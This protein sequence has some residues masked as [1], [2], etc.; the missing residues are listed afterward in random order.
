MLLIS[1]PENVAN[2]PEVRQVPVYDWI[3]YA[4]EKS[5]TDSPIEDLLLPDM[6]REDRDLAVR[7]F[8]RSYAL[9]FESH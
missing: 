2:I 8:D 4:R 6:S 5:L 9:I 7:L 3:T 1:F